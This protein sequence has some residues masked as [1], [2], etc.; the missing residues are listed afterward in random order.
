M[1]FGMRRIAAVGRAVLCTP[2]GINFGGHRSDA[3]YQNTPSIGNCRRF[4]AT[5]QDCVV[6]IGW[7]RFARIERDDHALVRE[8]DFYV[9][10]PW[11][12]PQH[13]SQF[14]HALIAIFTFGGNFD[15]FPKQRDP[16]VSGKMD[17]RGSGSV[18]R[19]GSLS[20]LR[21]LI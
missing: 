11:N 14:A 10:Y 1:L 7:M 20:F 3:P 13:R 4:I 15:R 12:F 19:A 16:R 6:Q 2:M 17:R 8:I 18:G 9:L 5:L 21:F